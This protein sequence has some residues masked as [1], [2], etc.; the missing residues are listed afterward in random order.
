MFSEYSVAAP[1][2]SPGGWA[3]ASQLTF[4]QGNT[5][6]GNVYAGPSTFYAWNQGNPV[7]WA[8]W[9]GSIASGDKCGSAGEHDSGACKGPFGQDA[10]SGFR[11]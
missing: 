7:S 11:A 10:G 9:T 8:D 5:W 4:Y 3:I 6:S 2:T 1:Y